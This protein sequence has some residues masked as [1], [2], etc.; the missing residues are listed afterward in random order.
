[1]NCKICGG[2]V[3][4]TGGAGPTICVMC[5]GDEIVK[6]LVTSSGQTVRATRS[7]FQPP[8]AASQPGLEKLRA[9][10]DAAKQR[11]EVAR[12]IAA[13]VGPGN[14]DGAGGFG[15]A[16]RE[17]AAARVRYTRALIARTD[18]KVPAKDTKAD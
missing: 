5:L 15:R 6:T 4:L 9:E 12:D 16:A 2:E 13:D 8:V 11:Y 17:Y 7:P 1:M 3:R 14:P 10:L 18:A